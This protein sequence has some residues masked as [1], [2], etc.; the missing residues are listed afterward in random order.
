MLIK[1]NSKIIFYY[2]S[3]VILTGFFILFISCSSYQSIKDKIVVQ[4]NDSKLTTKQ[5]SEKLS[6]ELKNL[7]SLSVKNP[8]A[9]QEIKNK[10]IQN[11]IIEILLQNWAIENN[12]FIKEESLENEIKK[13]R[14][15]YPDDL[16]FRKTLSEQNL[17]F[18]EWREQIKISLLEKEL[19]KN[20]S[21]KI[22]PINED[23]VKN[24]YN[25]NIE[26]FRI[27]ESI[28]LRHIL[29][30]SEI[31]AEFLKN[32]LKSK[33]FN[34][35]A[36]KYSL[37]DDS[38][39]EGALDNIQKG[40]IDYFEPLFSLPINSIK[41]IES[42]FGFHLVKIEKKFPSR[43]S[44]FLDVKSQIIRKF[45]AN[46]EQSQYHSWIDLQLKKTIIKK[47]STLINSIKIETKDFRN[48]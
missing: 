36:T 32:K 14:S 27:K 41:I 20:L 35:L 5:F 15:Q 3:P 8:K 42:P 44:S 40:T 24:Y 22:Q 4:V 23:E 30:K 28:Q 17:S 48:D 46:S 45:L 34:E 26:E 25:S 37:S 9:I 43:I 2:I 33:S 13:I 47:D 29:V 38:R 16:V 6:R 39:Y 31:Q 12:I 11:F 1:N 10:I 21:L 19:F 7:N 18:A